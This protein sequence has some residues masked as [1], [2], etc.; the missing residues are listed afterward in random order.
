MAL[1]S[2][3]T[4]QVR[5]DKAREYQEL[6]AELAAEA[7]KKQEPWH[8]TSYQVGFGPLGRIYHVSQHPDHADIEK[9]GDAEAL[10]TRV[11][12]E[13]KGP[14]LLE[15]AQDCLVSTERALGIQ[16]PDLSNPQEPAE[17]IAQV[18]SLALIRARPGRQ[19]AVEKLLRQMAEAIPKTGEPGRI[20]VAQALTG[21][22]LLYWIVRPLESLADLDRQSIGRDLLIK[23]L[24][25][26]E[27]ERIFQSGLENVDQ[28][29]REITFYREDLSNPP[30]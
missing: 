23:A 4:D 13:K 22:M 19:Q 26:S 7:R 15:D 8:W 17:S 16:R 1:I 5:P 20:G 3:F 2:V 11:L 9:Q 12:G 30:R 29:Q 21:D 28:L 27:G 18:S 14:K 10:F 6:V 25:Q 24:G